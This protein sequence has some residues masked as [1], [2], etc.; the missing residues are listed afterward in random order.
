MGLKT[1]IKTASPRAINSWLLTSVVAF[2]VITF[3][4]YWF[5]YIKNNEQ[6]QISKRF[7]VLS[8][9]G[10]NIYNRDKGFTSMAKNAYQNAAD[11]LGGKDPVN[12]FDNFEMYLKKEIQDAQLISWANKDSINLDNILQLMHFKG[13]SKDE[14]EENDYVIYIDKKSFF[15]PLERPDVFDHMIILSGPKEPQVV[16]DTFPG[17]LETPQ[18]IDIQGVGKKIS[19][20]RMDSIELAHNHYK[21]F[22]QP[23]NLQNNQKWYIIGAIES[24]KFNRLIQ[25]MESGLAIYI[26]M[27]FLVFIFLIPILK[28][29]L[30]SSFDQLDAGDAILTSLSVTLLTTLL[31][32]ISLCI[33]QEYDDSWSVQRNL[34]KLSIEIDSRFK[35][36]LQQSIKKLQQFDQSFSMEPQLEQGDVISNIFNIPKLENNE[37]DAEN[38]AQVKTTAEE[39]IPEEN[40]AEEPTADEFIEEESYRAISLS[41]ITEKLKEVESGYNLYKLIFWMDKEGKQTVNF[42]TRKYG[43]SLDNLSH[44]AYFKEAGNWS[45]QE[46]PPQNFMLESIT[47]ITSGEKMAA[48]STR[49]SPDKNA[50]NNALKDALV[51]AMTSQFT[52]IIGTIMPV[53]YGFCIIDNNGKVWFHSNTQN[54]LQENFIAETGNNKDLLSAISAKIATHFQLNYQSKNHRA[55]IKPFKFMPLFLVTFQDTTYTQSAHTTIIINTVLVMIIILFFQIIIFVVTGAI[56]YKRS[57]LK[58]RYI[59]FDWLRPITTQQAPKHYRHLMI[60]NLLIIFLL[61][62]SR[63]FIVSLNAFFVLLSALLIVYVFNY[64][65]IIEFSRTRFRMGNRGI[66]AFLAGFLIIIYLFSGFTQDWGEQIYLFISQIILMSVLILWYLFKPKSSE[67]SGAG[68]ESISNLS[69]H[70]ASAGTW[71]YLFMFSWLLLTCA[72]PTFFFFTDSYNLQQQI[73]R[74]YAQL[75]LAKNIESRNLHIDRFFNQR[76]DTSGNNKTIENIRDQRK[77]QGIYTSVFGDNPKFGVEPIHPNLNP[78]GEAKVKQSDETSYLLRMALDPI[79]SEQRGLVYSSSFDRS[80]IWHKDENKLSLKYEI[81]TSIYDEN[82]DKDRYINVESEFHQFLNRLKGLP[83]AILVFFLILILGFT[84]QLIRFVARNVFA[85]HLRGEEYIKPVPEIAKSGSDPIISEIQQFIRAGSHVC[86]LCP[87]KAQK[88]FYKNL[89]KENYSFIEDFNL[90]TTNIESEDQLDDNQMIA[91]SLLKQLKDSESPL[92]LVI[93]LPFQEIIEQYQDAA[94]RIRV[95]FKKMSM[96]SDKKEMIDKIEKIVHLLQEAHNY[97][98]PVH[99]PIHNSKSAPRYKKIYTIKHK[100]LKQLILNEFSPSNYFEAIEADVYNGYSELKRGKNSQELTEQEDQEISQKLILL[101]QELAHPYYFKL[102]KSCSRREKAL[103]YDIAQNRLINPTN[104]EVISGLLKKGLLKYDGTIEVMNRSFRNY[105]LVA[106]DSDDAKQLSGGLSVRGR[107]K[108]Y[109]APLYLFILGIAIF[110]AFQEDLM[111]DINALVASLI[112]GVGILTKFSGIFTNLSFG[113]RINRH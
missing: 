65:S 75:K 73:S 110:L 1:K 13:K 66:V 10:E 85:L 106:I 81:K 45:L 41:A 102:L 9:M 88:E 82:T 89:S 60:S 12:E 18:E 24:S 4:L 62:L 14:E 17:D 33:Y 98:V 23:L 103:L 38:L 51:A 16:Y 68:K 56:N 77:T 46:F 76:M 80:R 63:W 6:D 19:A 107:W 74:K 20:G 49:R 104:K 48:I 11:K 15:T 31:V 95:N 109:R 93:S 39:N 43:G 25:S 30:L 67:L 105:I 50:V 70:V 57:L 8:Q 92:L 79:S 47:S 111:S 108:S 84:F 27:A 99:V 90:D 96:P 52:S 72:L 112:G 21:I 42:S 26:L 36:E 5:V 34:Q 7:R 69:R 37:A 113:K 29:F 55:Y 3:F 71:Y 2:I 32:F 28:L 86:I 94:N 58:N 78:Q 59:P 44:R 64:Y 53:G 87:T 100:R 61:I 22:L 97:F 40:L 101:I 91:K 35:E 83:L 54:N